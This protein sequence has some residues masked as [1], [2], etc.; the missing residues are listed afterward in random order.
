MLAIANGGLRAAILIPRFGEQAGHVLSTVI[1]CVIIVTVSWLSMPWLAPRDRGDALRI[2]TMWILLTLAFEFLAG[3]Y[4][5]RVSWDRILADYDIAR[6]RV[7][8]LV[9]LTTFIAPLL[10][11]RRGAAAATG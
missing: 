6:G 1:L 4:L 11:Y 3:H 8:P 5:F 9:P 7:W 10:T 2:G